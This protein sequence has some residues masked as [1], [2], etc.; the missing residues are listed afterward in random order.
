VFN[1]GNVIEVRSTS[2]NVILKAIT[3]FNSSDL[4]RIMGHKTKDIS[5]ILGD[6]PKVVFRP[7]DSVYL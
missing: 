2:G 5:R 7:E 1:E 3:S 4:L 6:V